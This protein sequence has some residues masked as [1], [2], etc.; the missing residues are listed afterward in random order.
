[1][2]NWR[3]FSEF[4]F[5]DEGGVILVVISCAVA[6][7]MERGRGRGRGRCIVMREGFGGETRRGIR[8]GV[9]VDAEGLGVVGDA[10]EGLLWDVAGGGGSDDNLGRG[11]GKG[12]LEPGAARGDIDMSFETPSPGGR[13]WG[14]RTTGVTGDVR[15]EVDVAAAAI[16]LAIM[17]STE[18]CE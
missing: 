14:S 17:V 10:G 12:N 15:G 1:V 3:V 13:S 2:G 9:G 6:T 18:T 4:D 8:D 11:G 5:A 16:V 7:G